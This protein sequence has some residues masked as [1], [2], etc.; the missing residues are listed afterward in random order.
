MG[1]SL[2]NQNIIDINN[3]VPS[4]DTTLYAIFKEDI[5]GSYQLNFDATLYG[6]SPIMSVGIEEE[7]YFDLSDNNVTITANN[8]NNVTLSYNADLSV[9]VYEVKLSIQQSTI[10][11]A[12]KLQLTFNYN[13]VTE[14]WDLTSSMLL[15]EDKDITLDS[16]SLEKI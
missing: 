2:D 4:Q 16:W 3:F 7:C 14:S 13:Y 6:I 15:D 1:W 11:D 10:L 8:Y 5:S 9:L 12:D